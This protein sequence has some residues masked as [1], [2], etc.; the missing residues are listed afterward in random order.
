MRQPA[1]SQ[2]FRTAMP[3]DARVVFLSGGTAL[4]GLSRSMASHTQTA[5]HLVTPFDSGG[6]SAA[7]RELGLPAIGDVRNRLV[8]L[9]NDGTPA[10]DKMLALLGHRLPHDADER[11]WLTFDQMVAGSHPLIRRAPPAVAR[12]CAAWLCTFE[13]RSDRKFKLSGA[14]VGN[15]VLAGGTF[16]LG[17]LT[18]AAATLGDVMGARSV[19]RPT[20]DGDYHLAA[21]LADGR[22]V[23][24]QHLLTGKNGAP[25]DCAI[26]ALQLVADLAGQHAAAPI[27]SHDVRET[28]ERADLVVLPMGSFW[29]SVAANLLPRGIGRAV[30]HA[31]GTTIYVPNTGRDPEQLGMDIGDA[32][33]RIVELVRRD[34]GHHTPADDVL[35]GVLVDLARGDYRDIGGLDRV[36][37]AGIRVYDVPLVGGGDGTRLDDDLLAEALL[38]LAAEVE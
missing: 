8:S 10:G 20:V 14:S 17:T 25:L 28:I 7:L 9:I 38:D 2:P 24:G 30:V 3:A 19:V 12:L 23:V 34:V 31:R 32:V 13:R 18:A 15:L 26:T 21:T 4:R 22:R 33:E 27:A 6:S 11:L 35:D 29:T 5:V 1:D 36:R 16:E 37:A